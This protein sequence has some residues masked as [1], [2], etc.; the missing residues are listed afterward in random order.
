MLIL[1]QGPPGSG[2]TTLGRRLSKAFAI[3]HFSKDDIKESLFN[4]LGVKDSAW[5]KKLGSSSNSILLLLIARC[6]STSGS[7]IVETN[8]TIKE[9]IAKMKLLPLG[10][11]QHVFELYLY[12]PKNVLL[13]R[14]EARW[15]SSC[16]HY[17][18]VDDQ[19][20]SDIEAYIENKISQPLEIGS[21]T[22][23][24]DTEKKSSD[25]VFELAKSKLELLLNKQQN[26]NG[27]IRG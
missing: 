19:R 20:Y 3:P 23:K 24:V 11:N 22:L 5:S 16:R 13:R 7:I 17:G 1:I 21:E 25:E 10:S 14:I 9:D 18:H 26:G 4:T 8:F 15:N 27:L 12:A 2:K 6:C